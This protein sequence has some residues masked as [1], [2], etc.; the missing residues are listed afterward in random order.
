MACPG[1]ALLA[2][3]GVRGASRLSACRHDA[4][5]RT[6]A[7]ALTSTAPRT[8]S[9]SASS[10]P[11]AF[12]RIGIEVGWNNIDYDTLALKPAARAV[13]SGSWALRVKV[14]KLWHSLLTRAAPE[15]G[16]LGHGDDTRVWGDRRRRALELPTHPIFMLE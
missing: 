3:R 7:K 13:A 2:P 9:S 14:C 4:A 12:S 11:L 1:R 5:Q 15:A 6:E 8:T 16:R 10:P